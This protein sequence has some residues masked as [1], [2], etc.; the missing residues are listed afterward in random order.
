M[1][2]VVQFVSVKSK[3]GNSKVKHVVAEGAVLK[4][5]IKIVH[6]VLH[7]GEPVAKVQFFRLDVEF[8]RLRALA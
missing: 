8:L 1:E 7:F 6:I 2:R 3:E 5:E 4:E